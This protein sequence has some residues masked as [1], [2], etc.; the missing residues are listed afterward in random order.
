MFPQPMK[1]QLFEKQELVGIANEPGGPTV[2]N[3]S[4][5]S[6]LCQHHQYISSESYYKDHVCFGSLNKLKQNYPECKFVNSLN[7]AFRF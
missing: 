3:P 6:F 2:W 4:G 5:L 7:C 1:V